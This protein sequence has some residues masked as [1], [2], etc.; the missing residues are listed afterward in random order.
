MHTLFHQLWDVFALHVVCGDAG[1]VDV[2]ALQPTPGE[3]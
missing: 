1:V 3:R 2:T